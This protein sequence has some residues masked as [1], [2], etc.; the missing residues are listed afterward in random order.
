MSELFGLVGT[1][2]TFDFVDV[3]VEGDTPLFI[4]PAV[5]A[6]I[7]SPWANDCTSAIQG[8]F[9]TV[10][11]RIVAGDQAGAKRLLSYLGEDNSTHLGYSNVSR[12]SGLGRGLA[13]RF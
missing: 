6:R 12:G 1:Q 5:L 10:L 13:G 8:Y 7:G 11:D 9:Q 2:G 3:D 4:D